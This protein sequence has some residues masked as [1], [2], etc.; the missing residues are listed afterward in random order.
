MSWLEDSLPGIATTLAGTVL[1]FIPGTQAVGIP[2]TMAG[3][4][5]YGTEQQNI[6][7]VNAAGNTQN[8]NAQQAN[9]QMY[10][11]QQMSN[12]AYQR[13][14]ADMKAAGVNP[15]M[16]INNGGASS[17]SGSAASGVMP[18]IENAIGAGVSSATETAK[19]M[20]AIKATDASIGLMK[21]QG[22]QAIANTNATNFSAK[23]TELKNKALGATLDNVYSQAQL[24]AKN[25]ATD[26]KYQQY[27]QFANRVGKYSGSAKSMLNLINPF[28][29]SL[30]KNSPRYPKN[31]TLMDSTT[32]EI[33]NEAP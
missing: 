32:G 29:N 2:M 20:N 33:L 11:Q 31:S 22:A 12:T 5:M 8:F 15:M 13:V 28:G 1:D 14:T 6:A 27:D 17:P 16:A 9:N 7:Q 23:N 25:I 30:M 4:S 24:D 18:K 3:L 19:L 26:T 10:F 21:L